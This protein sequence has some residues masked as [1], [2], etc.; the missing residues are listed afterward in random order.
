MDR[1]GWVKLHTFV[2]GISATAFHA[3][4]KREGLSLPVLLGRVVR[5]ALER[6]CARRRA[7]VE[8]S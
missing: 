8:D 5:E 7:E 4:A 3:W 2:D 6:E 1:D